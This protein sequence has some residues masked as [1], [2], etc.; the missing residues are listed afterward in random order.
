MFFSSLQICNS[1]LLIK[2]KPAGNYMFK[3]N[4]RNTRIR[5]EICSKFTIKILYINQTLNCFYFQVN[6]PLKPHGC[7]HLLIILTMS[8]VWN[9]K[10]RQKCN[11]LDEAKKAYVE[12]SKLK[13]D[14]K[15]HMKTIISNSLDGIVK[16]I[17]STIYYLLAL[18][19]QLLLKYGWKQLIQNRKLLDLYHYS[20]KVNFCI[21]FGYKLN[22]FIF[23]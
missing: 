15:K 19:K 1:S 18:K 6:T 20:P 10:T 4:N 17:T 9:Q 12:F 8:I 21:V 22:H 13:C 16:F 23:F 7:F 5:C 14:L 3:V 2:D 11:L